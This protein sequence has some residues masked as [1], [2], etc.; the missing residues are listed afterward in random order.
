MV[1][2]CIPGER[3]DEGVEGTSV[4]AR[5]DLVLDK[6]ARASPTP[7]ALLPCSKTCVMV[8]RKPERAEAV[9]TMMKPARLNSASPYTSRMSPTLMTAITDPKLAL[10]LQSLHA[11]ALALCFVGITADR[12][13]VVMPSPGAGFHRVHAADICT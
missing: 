5:D 13:V 11:S 2:S 1:P 6:G 4:T 10:G 3:L 8:H 9:M 12:C 7:C